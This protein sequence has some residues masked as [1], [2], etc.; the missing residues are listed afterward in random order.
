MA[1]LTQWTW[2]L[3]NSG[4]QWRTGRHNMLQFMG[5]QRVGHDWWLS[6]SNIAAWFDWFMLTW[7]DWGRVIRFLRYKASLYFSLS[8]SALQKKV[9][10]CSFSI[11][12]EELWSPI[13]GQSIYINSSWETHLFS[14]IY[15]FTSTWTLGTFLWSSGLI[16]TLPM[17]GAQVW[18]LAG[19]LRSHMS[20]GVAKI[21]KKR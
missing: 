10:L 20:H 4:R 1:S 15:L 12:S 21:K 7:I 16:S 19:E 18:S 9:S 14:D 3:A 17:Q 13:W 5:P 6:N 8:G 2:I 11:R